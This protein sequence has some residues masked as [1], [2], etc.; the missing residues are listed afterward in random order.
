MTQRAGNAD[1]L[2]AFGGIVRVVENAFDAHDRTKLQ[3]CQRGGRIVEVDLPGLDGLDDS[4]WQRVSVDLQAEAERR[5]RTHPAAHTAELRA[6]DGLVQADRVAEEGLTA[7]RV[8]AEHF[9][10]LVHK[11]AGVVADLLVPGVSRVTGL[12]QEA[13]DGQCRQAGRGHGDQREADEDEEE[14]DKPQPHIALPALVR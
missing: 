5:L 2:Q 12:V 9:A 10:A 4:R 14:R 8:V 1:G 7:E 11:P 3:Q 6:L 13:A